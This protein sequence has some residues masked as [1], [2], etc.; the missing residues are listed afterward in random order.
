MSLHVANRAYSDGLLKSVLFH[1]YYNETNEYPSFQDMSEHLNKPNHKVSFV[2]I[3][4][5]VGST[6][7]HEREPPSEMHHSFGVPRFFFRFNL[8]S[9]I[10]NV[11]YAYVHWV[12]F[13]LRRCHRTS[14]EGSIRRDEWVSGPTEHPNINPFCYVEDI[15]PSRFALGT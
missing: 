11:P 4:D 7:Y 13:K 3:R 15:I 5:N 8:T 14:F 12:K 10:S 9:A 6:S 2:G 1:S